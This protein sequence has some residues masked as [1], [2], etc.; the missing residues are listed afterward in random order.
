MD[1]LTRKQKKAITALL[2]TTTIAE[3]AQQAGVKEATL[4]LWLKIPEFVNE[5]RQARREAYNLAMGRLMMN[6]V[7]AVKTL[8]EIMSGQDSTPASR[9]SAAT[10]TI[11]ISMKFSELDDLT[12]RVEKL[13]AKTL[14][15]AG[16]STQGSAYADL[17]EREK[18][19]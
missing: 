1:K 2:T 19:N 10:N 5:Y 4:H 6:T 13:E 3:A 8:N 16:E 18:D 14:P 17:S 9:V 15:E 11:N 7:T 12:K